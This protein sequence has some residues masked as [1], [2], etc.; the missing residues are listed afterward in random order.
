MESMKVT[1]FKIT[2]SEGNERIIEEKLGVETY[3]VPT[4]TGWDTFTVGVNIILT[5]NSGDYR[6]EK[7]LIYGGKNG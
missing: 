3:K 7:Y 1:K 6:V 2:D 4:L 5:N